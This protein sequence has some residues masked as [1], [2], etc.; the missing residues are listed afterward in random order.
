[1]NIQAQSVAAQEEINVR[2]RVEQIEQAMRTQGEAPEV[3]PPP[4]EDHQPP[5][6][7]L[8]VR[9]RPKVKAKKGVKFMQKA[10]CHEDG[11][12]CEDA[13]LMS[14]DESKERPKQV[15]LRRGI[16]MDTGAH[17]NVMPERMAGQRKIRPSPGSKKGMCYV[18]AG[19]EKI[20]NLGE[21]DF[22]FKSVEGHP[23]NMVFQ[24]ANVNKALGSVAYVVDRAY[25]VVYDKNMVTGEYMSYMT[26]KPTNTTYRFRRERNIWKL[27]AIVDSK[28]VYPGFSGPE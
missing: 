2:G 22:K 21:I 20:K 14:M 4:S 9:Q 12:G 8:R 23:A 15:K 24:I 16:T 6:L 17:D 1:M 25:R 19:N 10:I 11:C 3:P 26:H 27:D 13:P 18:A 5:V 28:D 7:A